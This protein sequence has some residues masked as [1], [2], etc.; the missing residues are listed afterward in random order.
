MESFGQRLKIER[1]KQGYNQKAFAELLGITPTRLNYWEK[2]KREPDVLNIKKILSVLNVDSDYLLGVDRNEPE[3][4]TDR[5]TKL[6]NEHIQ[7]YRLLT[8]AGQKAID[9]TI[10]TMLEY[11]KTISESSSTHCCSISDH[12]IQ[13]RFSEQKFSAGRGVY[14]GPE[15]FNKIQVE[16]N[17]MTRK[18]SFS[19]MVEGDS[20][21]PLY[22]DGDIL[23]VNSDELVEIDDIGI[24][25][26]DGN[27]YVKKL[28]YVDLISLNPDYDPILLDDSVR[29]NGKVIGVL[30]PAWIIEE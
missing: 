15:S 28:G 8:P 6:E 13:L 12:V 23:L 20:M 11:E 21:E 16:E 24:F 18:A 19:G 7:K 9:S 17:D 1:E 26:L 14:L 29:C 2:D 3:K 22:H 5:L 27:G 30:N 10:L 4:Y 25:T